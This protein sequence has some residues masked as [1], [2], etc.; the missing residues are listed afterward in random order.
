MKTRAPRNVPARFSFQDVLLRAEG[1]GHLTEIHSAGAELLSYFRLC[2]GEALS[3]DFELA[4]V[5]FVAVRARVLSS[6]KDADGY[7]YAD[8]RFTDHEFRS[9]LGAHLSAVLA[10]GIDVEIRR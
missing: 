5:S 9:R 10:G 6:A 8:I 4:G 3:L 1:W 2:R 7:F